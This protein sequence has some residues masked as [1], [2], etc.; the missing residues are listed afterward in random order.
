MCEESIGVIFWGDNSAKQPEV[1]LHFLCVWKVPASVFINESVWMDFHKPHWWHLG[2][3]HYDLNM[4]QLLVL[5][6]SSIEKYVK[7]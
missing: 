7:G 4:F 2:M 3:N 6:W 1:L 5:Q